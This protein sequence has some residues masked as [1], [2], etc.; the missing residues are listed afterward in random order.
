MKFRSNRFLRSRFL[1]IPFNLTLRTTNSRTRILASSSAAMLG[2]LI[3]SPVYAATFYWDNTSGN[4]ASGVATNWATTLAGGTNPAAGPNSLADDWYYNITGLN[5]AQTMG[6]NG[7]RSVLG[8]TF[9]STGTTNIENH[10]TGG[11]TN[12]L[13]IASGG[14]TVNS[15][16]GA[17]GLGTNSGTK[18]FMNFRLADNQ[19]WLNNSATVLAVTGSITNVGN[20][21]PYT[22]TLGG[23][24]AGGI[25]I[26]N[27]ILDGGTTGTTAVTVNNT[28][29]GTTTLSSATSLYTGGTTVNRGTLTLA[30]TATLGATTGALNVSNTNTGAGSASVLNLATGANTTVGNLS[31]LIAAPSS[32]TNTATINTQTG[33]NFSVTQ[34]ADATYAGVIASAGS[35]TLA[36]GST[37]ALTFTGTNTY[38]GTTS[39]NKGSLIVNGSISTSV[40][41]TVASGATI[42]GDGTT[43]ALTILAGGAIK[44][45]NSP[46][47]LDVSGNYIQA[48][49]YTAEIN[50]LIAG[51]GY[52]QINVIGSVDI[53]GGSLV[54]MFSGTYALNNMVFILTNNGTDAI[55]GTY[56]TFAQ[57][58][59]VASYGGFDWQISYLAN[60]VGSTFTGGNDIALMAIPEPNAAALLGSLG[61]IALLRRRRA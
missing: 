9:N 1:N 44:P 6:L 54:T 24:G 26:S 42:G 33:R 49:T 12:T 13:T 58:A 31:G 21:T 46:G 29:G 15:I 47:S 35:F 56:N 28:G 53:T 45:G 61:V 20:T 3:G 48:G 25:T 39:V 55:T 19:S 38:T 32:G 8:I 5:T 30:S 10:I 41:T 22:F 23:S 40:L 52:D 57:G 18:G 43:G 4:N 36:A 16:A 17:V 34:T 2:L 27:S 50:G 14:I 7:S 60:S 51:T 11:S 59:V 37:H